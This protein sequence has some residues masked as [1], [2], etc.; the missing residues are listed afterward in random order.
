MSGNKNGSTSNLHDALNNMYNEYNIDKKVKETQ[1]VQSWEEVMGKAIASKTEKIFI[2]QGKLFLTL[3]SAPLKHQLT[4][5]KTKI[6]E[7]LEEKFGKGI[8]SEVVIR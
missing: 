1:L 3:G 6:I 8:V 5:Q 7:K 4:L 2:Y